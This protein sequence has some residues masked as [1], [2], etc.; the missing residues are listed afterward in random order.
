MLKDWSQSYDAVME[1]AA[2]NLIENTEHY[3]FCSMYDKETNAGCFFESTWNDHYDAV[4]GCYFN[5][6]QLEVKG[7]RLYLL[8]NSSQLLIWGSEDIIGTAYALS[9]LKN[10]LDP[11]VT[12]RQLPPYVLC[13]S[14]FPATSNYIDLDLVGDT[15][16]LS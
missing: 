13:D 3:N 14:D 7:V 8:I 12:L 11:D 1:Q 10:M 9:K 15:E 4:R 6:P 16:L 5:F 2:K